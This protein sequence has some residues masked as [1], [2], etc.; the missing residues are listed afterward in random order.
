MP[1]EAVKVGQIVKVKVLSADEKTKRI[2]LSIKQLQ[3]AVE[4]PAGKP[5]QAGAKSQSK[6]VSK[7]AAKPVQTMEEKLAMLGNRWKVR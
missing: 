2:A 7:P 1:S 6:P 4:K 3:G 5:V